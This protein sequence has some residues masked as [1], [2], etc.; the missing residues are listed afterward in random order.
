MSYILSRQFHFPHFPL[1]L[2][3]PQETCGSIKNWKV[4]YSA[5]M[6]FFFFFF[7]RHSWQDM[8]NQNG[9]LVF[10]SVQKPGDGKSDM[11]SCPSLWKSKDYPELVPLH[12]KIQLFIYSPLKVD[13][14]L[15]M[16]DD[17]I[18]FSLVICD[19]WRLNITFYPT[20]SSSYFTAFAC[21]WMSACTC[22]HVC[23]RMSTNVKKN[24]K[25]KHKIT[26]AQI[27]IQNFC[28]WQI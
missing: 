14:R 11:S 20:F 25:K 7:I 6:C 27:L 24:K 17:H 21:V 26:A 19:K 22:S 9:V 15:N 3:T 5:F 23:K 28:V 16:A 1:S 10:G 13:W 12:R 4:K 8:D 18:K 2:Y